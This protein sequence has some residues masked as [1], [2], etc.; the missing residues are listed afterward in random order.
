MEKDLSAIKTVLIIIAVLILGLVITLSLKMDRQKKLLESLQ[1]VEVLTPDYDSI[2]FIADEP[3]F[4]T[5]EE[6]EEFME[7]Y[8]SDYDFFFYAVTKNQSRGMELQNEI[9][10]IQDQLMDDRE[11]EW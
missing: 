3:V 11:E 8:K 7:E 1:A 6:F 10:E 2:D 4:I 9:Y 5:R